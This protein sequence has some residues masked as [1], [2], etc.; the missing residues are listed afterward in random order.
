MPSYPFLLAL[1]PRGE[2]GVDLFFLISA[3][4][5]FLS[6]QAREREPFPRFAF[7][8]RRAFR[9]LP[10]WWVTILSYGWAEHR[11]PKDLLPS[12]G[13]YYGFLRYLPRIE[14]FDAQWSIFVEESFYLLLPWILSSLTGVRRAAYGFFIAF[15]VA[16]LW[17]LGAERWGVPPDNGYIYWFP[18][19]HW[20]FFAAGLLLAQLPEA[21]WNAF[22]ASSLWG[23][24]LPVFLLTLFLMLPHHE[25]RLALLPLVLLFGSCRNPLHPLGK[26]A[27]TQWLG[28][29]GK[30]SYSIYLGHLALIAALERYRPVIFQKTGLISFSPEIRFVVWFSLIATLCSTLGKLTFQHLERTTIGWG[31]R[32]ISAMQRQNA[33]QPHTA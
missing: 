22:M 1:V 27:R 5:L 20:Y 32:V 8:L 13:M 2:Y 16:T 3:Y 6:S 23:C 9:I 30:A 25:P 17:N 33:W 24:F 10:L 31:K 19:N 28:N 7:Y 26:L 15:Y 18:L 29:L 11:S 12:L 14:V 21:F 4:T